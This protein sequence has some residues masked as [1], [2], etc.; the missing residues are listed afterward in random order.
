LTAPLAVT[1]ATASRQRDRERRAALRRMRLVATGLL[2]LMLLLFIVSSSLGGEAAWLAYLR[3]FAEA[4]M[5]GACADWFAVVAIFR[6]PLGLPIPHTAIV[7]QNKRR[8]GDALGRFLARNFFDSG[9]INARLDTIDI[10]GWLAAW[11]RDPANVRLLVMWSRS[12]V[13]PAIELVGTPELRAAARHL[14]KNGIDSI[15]AAPLA[16]RVLAVL[17]AQDQQRA[18]FDW[19]LAAVIDFLGKN[20]A[21]MCQKASEQSAG[22]LPKWA[23]AKLTDVVLGGLLETV[24]AAR[25]PEHP[26]REEFAEFLGRFGA[27]LTNDPIL[28]DR[29]EKMKSD[30]LDTKLTEDYL[31]W[32]AAEAESRL[33][34]DLETGSSDLSKALEHG[35]AA[36][37]ERIAADARLRDALNQSARQLVINAIVPRRDEIGAYVSDVVANWDNETLVS[38]MELAVGKDLQFIRINGTIVGGAVGVFLLAVSRWL[39]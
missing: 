26:W 10:A 35:A 3:A 29:L 22:W 36:M 25:D 33:K 11:L 30:V 20:R 19:G 2:L 1:D 23:Q 24:A 39:G 37:A 34:I 16:G 17:V 31:A 7:L 38:R 13:P 27:R 6:R 5:V 15:A 4:G 9:E 28:Y 14:I 32:L 12:L 18:V 8:I 21:A